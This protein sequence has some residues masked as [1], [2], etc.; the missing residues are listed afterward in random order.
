MERDASE[1]DRLEQDRSVEDDPEPEQPSD[2]PEVPEA[3]ALEQ[4]TPAPLDDE[5]DD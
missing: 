1:A 2:D 5:R 4:A 3:D